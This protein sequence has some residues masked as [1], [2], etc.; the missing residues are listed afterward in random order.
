[1]NDRIDAALEF[2]IRTYHEAQQLRRDDDDE[3]RS[4]LI[5]SIQISAE[6]ALHAGLLYHHPECP[7]GSYF[8]ENTV[9]P[10]FALVHGGHLF[11][12]VLEECYIGHPVGFRTDDTAMRLEVIPLDCIQGLPC[13][14]VV[15]SAN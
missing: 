12:L 14:P 11:A 15:G 8:A 10:P 4:L 7:R 5:T 3:A 6:N 2:A 9:L 1:M 13:A